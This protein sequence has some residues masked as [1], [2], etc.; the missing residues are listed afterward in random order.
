MEEKEREL[1]DALSLLKEINNA[2]DTL[3][4]EIRINHESLASAVLDG[5]DFSILKDYLTY[6]DAK[7]G[8]MFRERETATDR[9][10]TVKQALFTVSKEVRMMEKLMSNAHKVMRKAQ[11]RKEQ[12]NLD[13]MA[14][15]TTLP[16]QSAEP[17]TKA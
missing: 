10:A 11:N 16:R 1:E 17:S 6:L 14:L 4:L 15:R 2:I 13:Q 12:K 5:R 3:D 9:I 8:E 7:K